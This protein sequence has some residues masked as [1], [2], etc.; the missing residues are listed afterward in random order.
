[1]ALADEGFLEEHNV[2]T[3]GTN[4]DTIKLAEDRLEF[5]NLMERIN[6]PCAA[7]IVVNHVNDAL[8]F[9]EKIGYPVVVRPAYTLGGTGG[10]IANNEKELHELF[11]LYA[12][13]LKNANF[14]Q[15]IHE[16]MVGELSV[17][18]SSAPE[19][20][21]FTTEYFTIYDSFDSVIEYIKIAG[22]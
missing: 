12:E 13:E 7:S 10:G 16:H 8:E 11:A 22:F 15:L 17:V 4:T 21:V 6:E 20:D 3:I 14:N 9:A 5:K 18:Y 19:K 1:M 2:R